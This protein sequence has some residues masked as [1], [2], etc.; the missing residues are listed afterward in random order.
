MMTG[1]SRVFQYKTILEV[2]HGTIKP[3]KEISAGSYYNQPIIREDAVIPIDA[4]LIHHP[5][6]HASG[7]YFSNSLDVGEDPFNNG[8][9]A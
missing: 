6:A 8:I 3:E 1:M 7:F 5:M 9:I 4:S 2:I